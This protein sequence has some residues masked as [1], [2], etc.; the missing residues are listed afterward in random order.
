[1]RVARTAAVSALAVAALVGA[2]TASAA[3]SASGPPRPAVVVR[4][5]GQHVHAPRHTHPG[6]VRVRN[7]GKR[8]V[9]ILDPLKS[10]GVATLVQEM[11]A[12]NSDSGQLDFTRDF[13]VVDLLLPHTGAYVHLKPGVHYLLDAEANKYTATDV[14]AMQAKGAKRN[15]VAPKATMV[16][17]KHN[18]TLTAVPKKQLDKNGS[19]HVLNKGTHLEEVF[20]APVNKDVSDSRLKKFIA[21]PSFQGLYKIASFDLTLLGMTSPHRAYS[22]AL[23]AKAG[24]HLLVALSLTGDE[25][26]LDIRPGQ[27]R[28]LNLG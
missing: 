2:G 21:K 4:V 22:A 5:A 9:L 1:M 10:A 28:L 16:N 6:L 25:G 12:A 13:A 15:T 7:T 3:A 14:T 20:L 17:V 8:P 18:G 24:R 27:V 19:V 11:N 26:M 23:H